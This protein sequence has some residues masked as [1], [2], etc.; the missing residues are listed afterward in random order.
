MT[1]ASQSTDLEK[2]LVSTKFAPPRIGSRYVMR[3]PL[4]EA[5][6]RDRH[7]RLLLV[8]GSAGF[9]KT[10]LLAQWRQKLMAAGSQVAWLSLHPDEKGFANFRT[11]MLVALGRMGM[12]LEDDLLLAEEG[13]SQV[14]ETVAAVINNVAAMGD[15]LHLMLDD[16]HHV[17]DPR[18]HQ[19]LQKLLDHCPS[20]LHIVIA[21]RAQP[22]LS[23][24]RLRV[25]GQVAEVECD[26]LPF[27]LAETRAFLE[28]NA[29]GL[30]LAADEVGVIH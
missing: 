5:L 24:A 3:E 15:E 21:S 12:P 1:T 20:N 28:Q 2:L 17:E 27:S 22:P 19:L 13:P 26:D 10:T 7:C 9:G 23:V 18:A 8:T 29:A 25:M 6:A 30:K 11:H 16:Y 14:D 4:L